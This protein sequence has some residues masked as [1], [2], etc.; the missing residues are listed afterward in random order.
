[1]ALEQKG[2]VME[3]IWHL[4]FERG[5]DGTGE[6]LSTVLNFPHDVTR[7]KALGAK[8][9]KWRRSA[10]SGTS[11]PGAEHMAETCLHFPFFLEAFVSFAFRVH[12]PPASTLYTRT[13]LM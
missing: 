10:G 7:E 13:F 9:H 11:V 6:A 1:M 5:F 4:A 12:P 2:A 3:A 8:P